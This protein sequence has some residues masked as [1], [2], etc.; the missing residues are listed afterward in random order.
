MTIT[1]SIKVEYPF[2]KQRDVPTKA[3][4][5]AKHLSKDLPPLIFRF[6]HKPLELHKISPPEFVT[7]AMPAKPAFLKIIFF[8]LYFRFFKLISDLREPLKAH[9]TFRA[10]H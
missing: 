3:F 8:S 4:S 2:T 10:R 6:S 9:D 7:D 5:G 1:K